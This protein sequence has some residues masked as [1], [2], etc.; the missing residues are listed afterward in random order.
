MNPPKR[1]KWNLF[2]F[3]NIPKQTTSNKSTTSTNIKTAETIAVVK[4]K[5]KETKKAD[6]KSNETAFKCQSFD[7]FKEL[8][9]KEVKDLAVHPKK[10]TELDSWLEKYVINACQETSLLLVTGPTGCGKS[11]AIQVLCKSKGIGITEWFNPLNAPT[12]MFDKLTYYDDNYVNQVSQFTEFVKECSYKKLCSGEEWNVCLIR[13]FP[14]KFLRNPETFTTVLEDITDFPNVRVIFVST[15]DGNPAT[16]IERNLFP[17][18]SKTKFNIDVIAFNACA[19]TLMKGAM[20]RAQNLVKCNSNLFNMPSDN[21]IEAICAASTGDIRCC[22]FQFYLAAIKGSTEMAVNIQTE[23]LTKTGTKRKRATKSVTLKAKLKDESLGLFHSVGRVL[24]P[25]I[26]A[27]TKRIHHDIGALVDEF[28]TQPTTFM[29]FLHE[30][31]L[32]Y[33]GDLTDVM[34]A[35]TC[36]SEGQQL[37]D[38]WSERRETDAIGLYVVVMGFMLHNKH[39]VS[40]WNPIRGPFKIKREEA[41]VSKDTLRPVS[42]LD[43]CYHNLLTNKNFNRFE[44][45]L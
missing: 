21:V 31:Y 12:Y 4:K 27:D 14:N 40:M 3:D 13:E 5:P 30:N 8:E 9:P 28:S 34:H 38:K 6:N 16:S 7:F 35:C 45:K 20:K 17:D 18:V 19:T 26:D 25:K 33:F 44:Q 39:R 2:D 43:T 22:V 42:S 29:G 10:I 36:L 24:H 1:K 15:D 32:R 37:M 23:T 41:T 11:S